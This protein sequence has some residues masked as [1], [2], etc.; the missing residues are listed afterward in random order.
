MGLER[1][2]QNG[3]Q[4]S[5]VLVCIW[6]CLRTRKAMGGSVTFQEALG[7]RLG[8]MQPSLEQVEAIKKVKNPKDILTPG[9]E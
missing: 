2:W 4:L 8:L 6:L 3:E 5:I 1:R 9:I 7:A